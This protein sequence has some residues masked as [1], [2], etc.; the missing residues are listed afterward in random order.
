MKGR[1]AVLKCVAAMLVAIALSACTPATERARTSA[2]TSAAPARL[3]VVY[4]VP[5]IDGPN[6]AVDLRSS[7]DIVKLRGAPPDFKSFI[8]A[9][10]DHF[11][12]KQKC[13]EVH[14]VGGKPR[15]TVWGV[16]ND[17]ATGS[18]VGCTNAMVIWAKKSGRWRLA[19]ENQSGWF[20][21]DLRE[22]R[23]PREITDP[24][25]ATSKDGETADGAE[26]YTGPG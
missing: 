23:V 14:G 15:A 22:D 17:V 10:V 24:E 20:C 3:L 9:W 5:N 19:G 4:G 13:P 8:G 6:G 11:V 25:C 16:T 12:A 26:R 21:S 18:Y 2:P 7:A 1:S